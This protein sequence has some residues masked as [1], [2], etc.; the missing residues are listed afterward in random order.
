MIKNKDIRLL[1]NIMYYIQDIRA[2]EERL[3]FER[4]RLLKVTSH[5]S[6]TGGRGGKPAT[7]DETFARLLELEQTHREKLNMYRR[8]MKRADDIINAIPN[9]QMKTFV[10]MAYVDHMTKNEICSELKLSSWSY[11]KIRECLESAPDMKSVIWH[12][13]FLAE[14]GAG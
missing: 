11:R 13:R 3:T 14:N 4:G 9:E 7:F 5:L 2:L 6:F 10:S 1:M 12:N 8:E